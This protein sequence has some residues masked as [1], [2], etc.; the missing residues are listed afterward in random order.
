MEGGA[1]TGARKATFYF[2][3]LCFYFILFYLPFWFLYFLSFF[4]VPF[5]FWYK[6]QEKAQMMEFQLVFSARE[7]F[8][9]LNHRPPLFSPNNISNNIEKEKCYEIC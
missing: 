4:F 9:L 6:R 5:L 7:V 2:W 8:F 1:E 3:V